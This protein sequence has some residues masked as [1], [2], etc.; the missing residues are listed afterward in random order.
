MLQ[1]PTPWIDSMIQAQTSPL[2]SSFSQASKSLIGRYRLLRVQTVAVARLRLGRD[3]CVAEC[4]AN[5]SVF[6][7]LTPRVLNIGFDTHI[8][9]YA[10][11]FCNRWQYLKVLRQTRIISSNYMQIFLYRLQQPAR[12]VFNLD[13]VVIPEREP[14]VGQHDLFAVVL[15][16]DQQP[17]F[18]FEPLYVLCIISTQILY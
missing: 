8:I 7:V 17:Q 11:G 12:Q 10:T 13:A 9:A 4:H 6:T 15:N 2:A 16:P 14:A 18:A 1:P 5:P 3:S